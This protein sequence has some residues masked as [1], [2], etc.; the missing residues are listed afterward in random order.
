MP[1][2]V[3]SFSIRVHLPIWAASS[4]RSPSSVT[5]ITTG[6]GPAR[7]VRITDR[8]NHR[9]DLR[10]RWKLGV[11]LTDGLVHDVTTR[12]QVVRAFDRFL[13]PACARSSVISPP[14]PSDRST[15]GQSEK[16]VG[17]VLRGIVKQPTDPD[18]ELQLLLIN[19]GEMQFN[20]PETL[21]EEYLETSV[22]Q[23][24]GMGK[25]GHYV[26]DT[27]GLNIGVLRV[28]RDTGL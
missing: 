26:I 25:L 27:C 19:G 24:I 3:Q 13:R 5:G 11:N 22:A 16:R 17:S 23:R 28:I 2:I 6:L 8:L 9:V 4:T 7:G 18:K 21:N 14:Q 15:D 20:L 1:H 12:W 10:L